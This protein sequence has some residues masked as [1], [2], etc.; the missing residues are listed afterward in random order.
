[1]GKKTKSGQALYDK[2]EA[3]GYSKRGNETTGYTYARGKE[4]DPNKP[5]EKMLSYMQDGGSMYP[6]DMQMMKRGGMKS[7]KKKKVNNKYK[8]GGWTHSGK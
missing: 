6:D 5:A 3:M 7:K 4:T 1:M 2:L 8:L